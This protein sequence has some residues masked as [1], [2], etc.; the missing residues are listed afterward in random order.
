MIDVIKKFT[1]VSVRV[2]HITP[3]VSVPLIGQY[4]S[5]LTR[6]R[7]SNLVSMITMIIMII[8]MVLV[9]N[10][11]IIV[12]IINMICISIAQ[13]WSRFTRA[14]SSSLVSIAMV[15]IVSIINMIC[16]SIAQY[17]S[18]FTRAC[19]SSL[20]SIAMVS[21]VIITMVENNNTI[22]MGSIISMNRMI[23]LDYLMI[24]VMCEVW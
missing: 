19:P 13:Y 4:W 24:S 16:I 7:S 15:I 9:D 22:N 18:R 17:W 5:H 2:T 20:V 23:K 12:S 10:M 6:A 11:I 1:W 3:Y 8:S 21:M 14:C